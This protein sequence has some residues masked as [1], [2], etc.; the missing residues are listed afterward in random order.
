M[1]HP[2]AAPSTVRPHIRTELPF[3]DGL[4][5]AL[6]AGEMPEWLRVMPWSASTVA[7]GDRLFRNPAPD[8]FSLVVTD[9]TGPIGYLSASLTDSEPGKAQLWI[10]MIQISADHRRQGVGRALAA[11][12]AEII[13]REFDAY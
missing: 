9:A 4:G 8:G 6:H 10:E 1:Q 5:F 13:C 12:L 7:C 2:L 3:A 11:G